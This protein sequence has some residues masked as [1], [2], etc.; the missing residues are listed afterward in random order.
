ML[1]PIQVTF[2]GGQ[3]DE[4]MSAREDSRAYTSG[5]ETAENWVPLAQGGIKHRPAFLASVAVSTGA[6]RLIK[7]DFDET[8]RYII[9]LHSTEMR[10][11]RVNANGTIS[12]IGTESLVPFWTSISDDEIREI[13]VAHRYDIM[14]LAHRNLP[15]LQIFRSDLTTFNVSLFRFAKRTGT[16]IVQ[17]PTYRFS[18]EGVTMQPCTVGGAGVPSV[19]KDATTYLQWFGID[20]VS[21]EPYNPSIIEVGS[22]VRYQGVA[23]LVTAEADGNAR[24]QAKA[25]NDLHKTKRLNVTY[26]AGSNAQ[27][28][29]LKETLVCPEDNGEGII[30]SV[31][32]T[33]IDVIVIRGEFVT[34]NSF[35]TGAE[36]GA[37]ARLVDGEYIEMAPTP[38]W[39]EQVYSAYRGYF[40]AAA[41]FSQRLWIGGSWDQ[42][43][44]LCASKIQEYYNFDIGD[45]GDTDAIQIILSANDPGQIRSL[46]DSR[47]LQIFTTTGE[48]YISESRDEVITPQTVSVF[49]GSS[50]FGAGKATPAVFA[51]S[52]YF[53]DMSNRQIRPHAWDDVQRTYDAPPLGFAHA[54]LLT[55]IKEIHPAYALDGQPHELMYVVNANGQLV[56][57]AE[58]KILKTLG[59]WPWSFAAGGVESACVIDNKPFLL[60]AGSVYRVQENTPSEEDMLLRSQTAVFK[61]QEGTSR[62]QPIRQGKIEV[63]VVDTATNALVINGRAVTPGQAA[64]GR[65]DHWMLGWSEDPRVEITVPAGNACTITAITQEISQ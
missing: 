2:D 17:A 61:T 59:F 40:S 43:A 49:S 16:D 11:L 28:W 63:E 47:H 18:G 14:I 30:S 39:E 27:S 65:I 35:L 37:Q 38:W 41:F 36:S 7:F 22:I 64:T 53:T 13:R 5:L 3:L 44:M 56:V 26:E 1:R 57:M 9:T 45:G 21:G 24:I 55:D 19:S 4:R 46:V 10:F 52:V 31:T 15:P 23:L 20:E 34:G 50:R 48:H 8:E 42:P 51:G 60:I 25:L 62:G 33:T 58:V 29:L 32:A 12:S 54:D 6:K